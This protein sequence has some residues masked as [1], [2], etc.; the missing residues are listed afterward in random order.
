MWKKRNVQRPTRLCKATAR[1]AFNVQRS[2]RGAQA[3][4]LL[5]NHLVRR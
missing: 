1:Q 5:A 3:A 4:K 2:I